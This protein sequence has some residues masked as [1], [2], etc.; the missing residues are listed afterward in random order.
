MIINEQ[1]F[2]FQEDIRPRP[3]TILIGTTEER[4][5]EC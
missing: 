2:Y 4:G 1:W 3:E 5:C